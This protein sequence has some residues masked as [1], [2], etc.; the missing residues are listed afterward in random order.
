MLFQGCVCQI[1]TGRQVNK[2]TYQILHYYIILN[3]YIYKALLY[4]NQW[5][6]I[7][8][9]ISEPQEGGYFNKYLHLHSMRSWSKRS[10]NSVFNIL[11]NKKNQNQS[12]MMIQESPWCKSETNIGSQ[13]N[14]APNDQRLLPFS[15]TLNASKSLRKAASAKV[16]SDASIGTLL[17]RRPATS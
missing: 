15:S 11:Q 9:W 16:R 13:P 1:P 6:T 7:Q 4:K 17:K 12:P 10:P 5:H 2:K 14:Q 3:I 8:K